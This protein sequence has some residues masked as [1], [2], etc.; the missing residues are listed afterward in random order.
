MDIKLPLACVLFAGGVI[1]LFLPMAA[2]DAPSEDQPSSAAEAAPTAQPQPTLATAQEAGG[3]AENVT[4]TRESDGHFY[5]DVMVEGRPYRMLV[6][7][8]ASVIAL[9]ADDAAAIGL[10]WHQTDLTTVAQGAGGPVEGM[11]TVLERVALGT[12]EAHRVAAIIVPDGLGIS[13]LG[14]SFLSS[15]EKVEIAG[16]RMVLGG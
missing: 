2:E 13:L 14:Q 12:H 15:L 5:A 1:G 16:D 10:Q 6:D 9:T 7:T 4:L 11:N 8:G 3:W